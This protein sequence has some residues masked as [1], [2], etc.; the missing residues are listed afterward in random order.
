M[1]SSPAVTPDAIGPDTV[2]YDMAYAKEQTPFERQAAALGAAA[3]HG[4][5]GMLVEQA[6][7]EMPRIYWAVNALEERLAA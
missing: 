4:G 7:E 2:C 3:T 5:W 1:E 6:A